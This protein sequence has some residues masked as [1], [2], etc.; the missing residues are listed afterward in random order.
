MTTHLNETAEDHQEDFNVEAMKRLFLVLAAALL[1]LPPMPCNASGIEAYEPEWQA[2]ELPSNVTYSIDLKS[3]R[4]DAATGII[5]FHFY[6][7]YRDEDVHDSEICSVEGRLDYDPAK[8]AYAYRSMNFER[9]NKP[10]LVD[11]LV[12]A[13]PEWNVIEAHTPEDIMCREAR[14]HL[15]EH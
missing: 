12:F 7:Q 3:I 10:V 4:K 2:V 11:A 1:M 8:Q 6:K 13:V 9:K 5:S 14:L 15:E